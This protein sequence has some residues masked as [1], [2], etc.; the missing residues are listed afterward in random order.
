MSREQGEKDWK[1]VGGRHFYVG[2]GACRVSIGVI[3]AETSSSGWNGS[4][5]DH[6]M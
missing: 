1:S 4:S 6:F 3:L 5:S 2:M